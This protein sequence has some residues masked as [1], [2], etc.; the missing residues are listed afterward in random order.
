MGALH[1]RL[2]SEL[3]LHQRWQDSVPRRQEL[4][5]GSRQQRPKNGNA[6][7][8]WFC[9]SGGDQQQWAYD[10]TYGTIYLKKSGDATKCADMNNGGM[11]DGDYMQ[12]WDCN[13]YPQQQF[14][15]GKDMST[16][17]V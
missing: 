7:G 5:L 2:L 17:L 4:L 8:I 14:D 1:W 12:I 16:M 11:N 3:G 9:S 10:Q 6:I 15:V 13:G